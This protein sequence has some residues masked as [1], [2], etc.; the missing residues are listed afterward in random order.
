[1]LKLYVGAGGLKA[2]NDAMR[3]E[4]EKMQASSK[5]LYEQIKEGNRVAYNSSKLNIKDIEA[6]VSELWNKKK[7]TKPTRRKMRK[8]THG[9]II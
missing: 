3:K 4:M 6:A 8:N 2:F 7:K 1:M 9:K 5:G